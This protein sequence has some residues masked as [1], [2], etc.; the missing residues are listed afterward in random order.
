MKCNKLLTYSIFVFCVKTQCSNTE[1]C[2]AC[3]QC[4][5]DFFFLIFKVVILCVVAVISYLESAC[6]VR[7]LFNAGSFWQGGVSEEV[8]GNSQEQNA[9]LFTD[10]CGSPQQQE[11]L[12][13]GIKGVFPKMD[14]LGLLERSGE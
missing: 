5:S 2:N 7:L 4:K 3:P 13:M 12:V 8:A 9:Q 11:T 6:G 1:K 14:S 10:L